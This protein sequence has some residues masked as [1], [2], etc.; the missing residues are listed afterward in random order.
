MVS[1]F[2]KFCKDYL[3]GFNTSKIVLAAKTF[4]YLKY[5]YISA[6]IY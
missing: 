4:I 5:Y 1:I 6:S 3:V 2:L